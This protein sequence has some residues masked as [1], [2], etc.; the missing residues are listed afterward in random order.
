MKERRRIKTLPCILGKLNVAMTSPLLIGFRFQPSLV[1]CVFCNYVLCI[2]VHP[3][4]WQPCQLLGRQETS[5][6]AETHPNGIGFVVIPRSK[7]YLAY[8]KKESQE[9]NI[10]L[11]SQASF[12]QKTL[13]VFPSHCSCVSLYYF[14]LYILNFFFMLSLQAQQLKW[15]NKCLLMAYWHSTFTWTVKKPKSN[16]V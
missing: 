6:W 4:E 11:F 8:Q 3:W 14:I 1:L 12:I 13:C 16:L 2:S 7:L 15:T 9:R 5:A 10:C